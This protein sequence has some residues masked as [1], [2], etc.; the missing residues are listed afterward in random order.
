MPLIV[1]NDLGTETTAN[2]YVTVAEFD[3]YWTDRGN[4]EAVGITD[5]E[6]LLIQATDYIENVYFGLWSGY[7]LT[8]TQNTEF[9]RVIDGVSV[10]IPTR[11]KN[12]CIELALKANTETL[13][14]DIE[15]RVIKEKVSSIEVQYA[16]YSD[17]MKQYSVVYGLVSPYLA[18]NSQNSIKVTR[19]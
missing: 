18:N 2:S 14:T 9:P 5:K 12:A 11:L 15:Q 8:T 17:Q 19:T 16:E 3:S 13:L 1:Q 7:S 10:G 4:T 6:P